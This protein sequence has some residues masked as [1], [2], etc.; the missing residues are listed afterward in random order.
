MT[1]D[2]E[3]QFFEA[4]GIEPKYNNG[5]EISDRYWAN[6]KNAD[7]YITFDNYMNTFCPESDSGACFVTCPFAYDKEEYPEITDRILL[8]LICILNSV[9]VELKSECIKDL[10]QEILGEMKIL[11]EYAPNEETEEFIKQ[12]VQS[13]FK[14]G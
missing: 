1:T 6:E 8:E 14:E 2:I 3:K 13:L 5:C 7:K 4:F 12:Q 11:L 10:K 9:S